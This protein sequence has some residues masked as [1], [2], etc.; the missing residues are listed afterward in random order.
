VL[1]AAGLDVPVRYDERLRERE[2]GVLDRLTLAGIRDRFPEQDAL[3][4]LLG[5]FY[6]RPPGGE[7]WCDVGLRVRS[8]LDELRRDRPGDRVLVVTHEVVVKM[9]RYVIEGLDEAGILAIDRAEVL[10]NCSLTRFRD[11]GSGL[12]LRAY[13]DVEPLAGADAPVTHTKDAAIGRG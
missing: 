7:R 12:A 5:K 9:A 11:D 1:A 4:G 3:R 13:N 2:F 8:V 6:H 10:A